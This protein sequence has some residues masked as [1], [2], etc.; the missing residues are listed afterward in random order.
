M[1]KEQFTQHARAIENAYRDVLKV[2]GAIEDTAKEMNGKVYN[3]RF[4]DAVNGKIEGFARVY[5]DSN[6]NNRKQ[7]SIYLKNR[8]YQ[9]GTYCIYFD[10]SIYNT[11]I[12][13]LEKECLTN[14]RIDSTKFSAVVAGNIKAIEDKIIIWQQALINFDRDQKKIREALQTLKDTFSDVSPVFKVFEL[15]SFDW[16]SP[17]IYEIFKNR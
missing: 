16:D 6:Y 3:K 1:K 2:W 17:E 8:S 7:L 11:S 12:W 14:W 5:V 15:H 13:D 9:Y 10:K 4:I